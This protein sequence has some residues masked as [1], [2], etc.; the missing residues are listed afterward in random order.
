M[1]AHPKVT[2]RLSGRFRKWVDKWRETNVTDSEAEAVEKWFMGEI[3]D[4]VPCQTMSYQITSSNGVHR[5]FKV[6]YPKKPE[7]EPSE[8]S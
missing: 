3:D 5:K 7:E 6:A 2:A 8:E 4:L 1:Q